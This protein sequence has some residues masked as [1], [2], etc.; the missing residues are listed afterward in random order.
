[1]CIVISRVQLCHLCVRWRQGF[2]EDGLH[3]GMAYATLHSDQGHIGFKCRL[4]IAAI[5][6]WALLMSL[7]NCW[8]HKCSTSYYCG[9]FI[10]I[11]RKSD[12]NSHKKG[13]RLCG[14]GMTWNIDRNDRKQGSYDSWI[15]TLNDDYWWFPSLD[16]SFTSNA[17]SS[18]EPQSQRLGVKGMKPRLANHLPFWF[19]ISF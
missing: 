17:S 12:N 5:Y 10:I 14:F 18:D 15:Y 7:W 6:S 11:I 8:R 13:N 3:S 4:G 16:L 9:T 1:M 2:G 19:D